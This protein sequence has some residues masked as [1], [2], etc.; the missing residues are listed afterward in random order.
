[1]ALVGTVAQLRRDPRAV[2]A[3]WFAEKLNTLS[4]VNQ[5]PQKR[6]FARRA[7]FFAKNG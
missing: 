3:D 1:V 6:Q 5:H 2:G 7:P 4:A